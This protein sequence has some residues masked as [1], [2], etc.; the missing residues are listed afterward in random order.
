[1]KE[2]L[3]IKLGGS[4]ITDKTR[5]RAARL[6]TIRRLAHQVRA[7]LDERP[8]LRLVM[9]HGSGSFGHLV[10]SKYGTRQG[11]RSKEEWRGFAEVAAAAAQLNQIV[12]DIFVGEG[13]PVFTIPPSASARCKSEALDYMDTGALHAALRAG[14][15]PLVYGDVAFDAKWGGTIIS[16]EKIFAY[17]AGELGPERILLAGVVTGVYSDWPKGE[18]VAPLVTPRT[19]AKIA[20]ALAGSHGKDVTGGMADKV[21]SMLA[22]VEQMPE[23]TVHIFSG[24]T[25]D[26][27]RRVIVSPDTPAGTRLAMDKKRK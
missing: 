14:L 24:M 23:L 21:K 6:R 9:G 1:M 5:E 4:L 7:A 18:T 17:L 26:L 8:H 11:V 27:L 20:P 16:T 3:F 2:T 10:A 19:L 13:V 12:T 25:R 22:L 15:V